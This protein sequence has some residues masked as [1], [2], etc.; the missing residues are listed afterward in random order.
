[1]EALI[2]KFYANTTADYQKSVLVTNKK[3]NRDMGGSARNCKIE[4]SHLVVE[5]LKGA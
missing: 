2:S 1:M 5:L 4:V 3:S